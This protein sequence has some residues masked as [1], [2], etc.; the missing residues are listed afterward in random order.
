MNQNP[1]PDLV[2][3][4]AP[5]PQS[6]S[7]IAKR[8]GRTET[9]C[10]GKRLS[11]LAREGRCYWHPRPG[12][13]SAYATTAPPAVT[14]AN[15]IEALAARFMRQAAIQT[16]RRRLAIKRMFPDLLRYRRAAKTGPN[17][18][19]YLVMLWPDGDEPKVEIV[20]AADVDTHG[21]LIPDSEVR[22]ELAKHKPDA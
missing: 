4:L 8:A 9:C 2:A 18:D 21:E 12:G 11:A 17:A 19:F 7:A 1:S 13:S 16:T 20:P 15:H 10:T 14:A 5:E 22:A 6:V 3:L